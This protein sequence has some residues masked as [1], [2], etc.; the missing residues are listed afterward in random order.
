MRIP[1]Q[2]A[3]EQHPVGSTHSI[4]RRKHRRR[5]PFRLTT[6]RGKIVW[7]TTRKAQTQN[8]HA[9]SHP[10]IRLSRLLR[11][12]RPARP[13]GEAVPLANPEPPPDRSATTR[14]AVRRGRP[15]PRRPAPGPGSHRAERWRLPSMWRR[16]GFAT[17][18]KRRWWVR[19]R[20]ASFWDRSCATERTRPS[21]RRDDRGTR[22]ARS[23]KRSE[24]PTPQTRPTTR[25]SCLPPPSV[26]S[27][28]C[29][30]ECCHE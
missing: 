4:I 21:L 23:E 25:A 9:R 2:R 7:W 1:G 14:S 20:P 28:P 13:P 15:T 12:T 3:V 17:T 16:C 27:C 10:R 8:L 11:T 26:R 18:R 24:N 6:F 29:P 19:L 5:T 22:V 30:S